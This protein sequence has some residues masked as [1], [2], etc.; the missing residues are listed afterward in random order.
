M[1][2]VCCRGGTGELAHA[3]GETSYRLAHQDAFVYNVFDNFE[4][5]LSLVACS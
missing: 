1:S 3:C 4:L 5:A 2:H